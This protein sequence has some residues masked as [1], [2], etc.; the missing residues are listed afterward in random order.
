MTTDESGATTIS[1][2]D[3]YELIR[4]EGDALM[5]AHQLRES[6]DLDLEENR[7]FLEGFVDLDSLLDVS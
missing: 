5:G 3:L 4:T 1:Q 7:K 6:F 2:H